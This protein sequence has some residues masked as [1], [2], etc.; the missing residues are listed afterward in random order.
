MKRLLLPILLFI[1]LP[2]LAQDVRSE[3]VPETRLLKSNSPEGMAITLNS[4]TKPALVDLSDTLFVKRYF[5]RTDVYQK[6]EKLEP[7]TVKKLLVDTRQ[8]QV[9]YQTGNQLK[10]LTVLM[11]LSGV[12]V[13]YKGIRGEQKTAMIRGVR[14]ATNPNVPNIEVEYTKRSL[15]QVLGGVG[16]FL[17]AVCVLE[18][19]NELVRK[20]VVLYNTKSVSQSSVVHLSRIKMGLT[21]SGRLGVEA[22]F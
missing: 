22:Q 21:T 20:A 19:S 3:E 4:L 6:G 14:T 7:A 10:T 17:G 1:T 13:G 18:L 12:Y 5:F 8:A 2:T 9:Y 16:L 11:A 15:P